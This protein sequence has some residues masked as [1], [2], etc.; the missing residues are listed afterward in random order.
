[1]HDMP[2]IKEQLNQYCIDQNESEKLIPYLKCFL[3]DETKSAECMA[4]VGVNP[5][6][7]KDCATATDQQYGITAS[8]E[9]K[10]TWR[11]GSFPNFDV[12]H[13]DNVKYNVGG[14]PTLVINGYTVQ[15]SRDS[16][17]LLEAMCGGFI[18]KPAECETELDTTV[19]GPGFGYGTSSTESDASCG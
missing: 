7:I 4:E 17:S 3:A 2:E 14:S 10:S 15:P 5:A 8:Y 6:V 11:S 12:Y 18:E 16:A 13:E 9:D 19:P 1:M